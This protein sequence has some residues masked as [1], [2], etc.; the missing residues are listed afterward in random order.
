MLLKSYRQAYHALLKTL[1]SLQQHLQG[2]D[3]DVVIVQQTFEQAHKLFTEQILKLNPT[4]IEPM[5]TS[6][7]QSIQ[8]EIH[9]GLRLLGTDILFWRTSKQ[10][11]TASTRLTVIGDRLGRLIDYCQVILE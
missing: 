2:S 6:R 8:T 11:A 5:L 3:P 4:E 10:N 1:L 9:R 7:W